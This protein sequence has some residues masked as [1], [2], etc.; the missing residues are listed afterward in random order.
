M[1]L[2][3]EGTGDTEKVAE[4]RVVLAALYALDCRPVDLGSGSQLFLGEVGV[5]ASVADSPPERLLGAGDPFGLVGG[6]A[7]KLDG[8]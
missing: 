2:E 1:E 3:V 5:E 4:F 6:H 8:S 7:S